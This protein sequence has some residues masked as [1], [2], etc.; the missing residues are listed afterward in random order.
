MLRFIL[1]TSAVMLPATSFAAIEYDQN[2]TPEVI[3]GSGNANGGFTTDRA[4]GLELGLRAKTRFP[5]P[6]NQFNSNGDGTYSQPAGNDAGRPLWSFEWSINT[7]WDG[8]TNLRFLRDLVYE[9]RIDTDPSPSTSFFT[10]DPVNDPNPV[11]GYWD[12]AIGDQFTGNGGGTVATS[13]SMYD[14]LIAS[15]NVAQNSWRMDFFPIVFNPNL[16]GIYTF[17]LIAFANGST[18]ALPIAATSIDVI[19]EDGGVPE[20]LSLLTWCGLAGWAGIAAR[21]YQ[22][23]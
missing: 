10:F 6:L 17:E 8:T 4:V 13:Q 2:V 19:V 7:S 1:I 14:G 11:T 12:H 9:L 16:A 21:R 20:P 3:F 5:V 23:A 18:T 22:R 15:K